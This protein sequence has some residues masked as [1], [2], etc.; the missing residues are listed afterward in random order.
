MCT[1]FLTVG[2][3]SIHIV[4]PEHHCIYPSHILRVVEKHEMQVDSL[5]MAFAD[6]EEQPPGL[7]SGQHKGGHA[8]EGDEAAGGLRSPLLHDE[9]LLGHRDVLILPHTPREEQTFP[10]EVLSILR[11]RH[12]CDKPKDES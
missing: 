6:E 8:S 10:S 7:N 1:S 2:F 5:V 3:L 9:A 4:H 12:H 11:E